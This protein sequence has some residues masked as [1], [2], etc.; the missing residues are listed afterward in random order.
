MREFSVLFWDFD[1]VI[2]DSVTVKSLAFE[3]LFLPYG[4]EVADRVRQHH[5]A[6]SGVSRFEKM[7]IYLAWAGEPVNAEQVQDFCDRFS[8]LVRQAV[9]NAAWVPG[10]REYLQAH[11]TRQ[12]FVL[13]T[14]TPQEEVQ[15]ILHALK[16]SHCFREVHGAPTP[17]A[18]AI[19]DVLERLQCLPEQALVVG[20]SESDL[21]AA[22]ANNVAFML[23][24]TPL[25]RSLQ[26]RFSGATFDGLYDE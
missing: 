5:E 7:P 18:M 26:E 15:Q 12:R 25:N 20:D 23:R 4:K 24:R 19:R 14:A 11:H 8:Q 21:N 13:V 2:K 9:I 1:G 16:I 6:H 3:Q 17:K 22:E 10:V